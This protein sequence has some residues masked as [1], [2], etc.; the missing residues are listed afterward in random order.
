V[1]DPLPNILFYWILVFPLPWVH[2]FSACSHDVNNINQ[3]YQL[4]LS[5]GRG[6]QCAMPLLCDSSVIGDHPTYAVLMQGFLE[7]TRRISI[8]IVF[9]LT[10]RKAID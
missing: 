1:N 2:N 6:P 4:E 9:G 7:R 10:C 3:L 5:H 8:E